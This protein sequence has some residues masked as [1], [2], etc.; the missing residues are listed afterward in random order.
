MVRNINQ[1]N[2]TPLFW[3]T[4]FKSLRYLCI[5]RRKF[6]YSNL[7]DFE[8]HLDEHWPNFQLTHWYNPPE[9]KISLSDK[10]YI[11]CERQN[12]NAFTPNDGTE[13]E[14]PRRA[15]YQER[16]RERRS[17]HKISGRKY[18]WRSM[19]V[20]TYFVRR[21]WSVRDRL[22]ETWRSRR[23]CRAEWTLR[24]SMTDIFY[25][26]TGAWVIFSGII[27]S[28]YILKTRIK[29]YELVPKGDS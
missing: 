20:I 26:G 21:V 19:E 11:L 10:K 2:S 9:N 7:K 15:A 25:F 27:Y 28:I 23:G 1:T 12:I 18:G 14:I 16:S 24:A 13:N 29:N 6:N 17:D 22:T 4:G 3:E 5:G 8:S